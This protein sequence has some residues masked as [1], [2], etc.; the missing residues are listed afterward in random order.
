MIFNVSASE[1][2]K[3]RWIDSVPSVGN[4]RLPYAEADGG[5]AVVCAKTFGVFLFEVIPRD[6]VG[7]FDSAV[8]LV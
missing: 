6:H 5:C 8:V 1:E 3:C 7:H 4:L 2:P